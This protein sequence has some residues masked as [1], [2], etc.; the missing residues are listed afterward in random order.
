MPADGIGDGDDTASTAASA[1]HSQTPSTQCYLRGGR[2]PCREDLGLSVQF[3]AV[4]E[5]RRFVV[6]SA[7]LAHRRSA[8]AKKRHPRPVMNNSNDESAARIVQ[9]LIL[10]SWCGRAANADWPVVWTETSAHIYHPP[11]NGRYD[12]ECICVG[13]AP[14]HTCTLAD[15]L[16]LLAHR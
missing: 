6:K 15:A 1:N 9:A 11:A 8:K 16:T 12:V 3:H 2:R 5:V 14:Y 13:Y 7:M 4:V 10:G